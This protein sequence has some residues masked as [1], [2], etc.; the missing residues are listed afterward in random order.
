MER[1][2]TVTLKVKLD[3]PEGATHYAGSIEDCACVDC[4]IDDPIWYKR[5]TNSTG[6]HDG[7]SWYRP[8]RQWSRGDWREPGWYIAT[9]TPEQ[10]AF[11]QEIPPHD[12]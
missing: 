11:L 7:W 2:F 9:T 4:E 12:L 10:P 6:T 8:R 1:T 3:V 5:S